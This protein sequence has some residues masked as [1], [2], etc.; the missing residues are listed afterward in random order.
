MTTILTAGCDRRV[1]YRR[2][3]GALMIGTM[4][5]VGVKI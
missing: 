2:V 3:G 4:A 1:T 5:A